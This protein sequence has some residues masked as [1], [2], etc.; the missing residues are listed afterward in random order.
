M[1]FSFEGPALWQTVLLLSASN[2]FMTFSRYVHL[3]HFNRE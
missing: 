1:R 3:K 2:V